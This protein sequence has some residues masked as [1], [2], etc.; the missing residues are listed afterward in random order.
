MPTCFVIQPFDNDKYDSRF[1]ETW[2]PALKRAGFDVYRVDKD[3]SVEIL[4]HAIEE[5]IQKSLICL[6]DIS[7]DNPNVWYELGYAFA[8]EK[9]VIMICSDT[10]QGRFPLDIQHRKVILYGTQSE[11]AY[12]KLGN[13]ITAAAQA[14]LTKSPSLKQPSD[15]NK[16]A[17]TI[18][19]TDDETAVL[20][21]LAEETDIPNSTIPLY[22]LRDKIKVSNIISSIGFGLAIRKL[23]KIKYI[24]T[25]EEVSDFGDGTYDAVNLTSDGWEWIDHNQDSIGPYS[26]IPF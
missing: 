4:I 17:P 12:V 5:G 1:E 10:R 9:S 26:N 23:T 24:E 18:Y 20:K 22:L 11:G 14:L 19:V 7:E 21:T 3:P 8:A 13:D 15:I 6:A 25:K 2:K 16:V